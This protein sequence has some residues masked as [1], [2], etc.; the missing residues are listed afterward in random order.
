MKFIVKHLID[1]FKIMVAR[2]PVMITATDI[3][4]ILGILGMSLTLAHADPRT[5]Q[6]AINT[7]ATVN[8]VP[9]ADPWPQAEERW[10]DISGPET[11]AYKAFLDG[12]QKFSYANHYPVNPATGQPVHQTTV[13]LTYDKAPSVPYFVGHIEARGLKPN[14]AYQL[15]LAG[16]PVKGSRGWGSYGD[17]LTN[18]RIGAVGRWWCDSS[19]DLQTNFNDSHFQDF[20]H[21]APSNGNPVHDIYAYQ[22]CG[23]FITDAQGNASIDFTSQSSYHVTWAE[24]QRIDDA[25]AG[26]WTLQNHLVD[27]TNMLY[28]GYGASPTSGTYRLY[29]EY[30]GSGRP[31]NNVVLPPGTY[32]CRFLITEESFHSFEENG[33]YWKTVLASE[34]YTPAPGGGFQPDTDPVNDIVFK[35]AGP[36]T[37][38]PRVSITTP[39][40]GSV[41]NILTAIVGRA[42]DQSGTG[43]KAVDIALR[44]LSDNK[45]WMGK[46][47]GSR[48]LLSAT[49]DGPIWT[50][51]SLP[52]GT[53]LTDGSYIVGANVYDNAAKVSSVTSSFTLDRTNPATLTISNPGHNAT[54][55]TLETINGTATD[56]SGGTGIAR[57]DVVLK[58]N[59]DSQ[60]WTGS[61]WGS[62]TLLR[63]TLNQNN[64]TY[65]GILPG[66]TNL[67][68][69]AYIVAAYAYDRAGNAKAV[70]HTFAARANTLPPSVLISTP[71]N[72]TAVRSFD[73]II[74]RAYDRS[75]S[76]IGRVDLALKRLSDN[77]Y[78]TGTVWGS[79]TLLATTLNGATWTCTTSLPSGADLLDGSYIVGANAYDNFGKPRSVTGT[80]TLDRAIPAT[81]TIDSPV[82]N[83]QVTVLS[84]INGT[85][86]DNSGGTGIVRVDMV[87]K[88]NSDG[89]YW[90]GN[91]WT[92]RTLLA[93]TLSGV[94]WTYGRMPGGSNLLPG[95]YTVAAYAYDY[96]RNVRSA[97]HNFTVVPGTAVKTMSEVP[98]AVR[99]PYVL[100]MASAAIEPAAIRLTF[101]GP[102]NVSIT[103]YD[104]RYR[105]LV[106]G[107]SILLDRVELQGS[108]VVILHLRQRTLD[109]GD[110]VKVSYQLFDVQGRPLQGETSFVVK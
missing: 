88:R 92:I 86:T 61:T 32:N 31:R 65:S 34:D 3:A 79:R 33:G 35:I 64:W 47:W 41:I 73:T 90:S 16:K 1:V 18:E 23:D 7:P 6:A 42:Y 46:A 75:G 109:S 93:A 78:W 101:T 99:S 56:N 53:D 17:D 77:K 52:I 20:Y 40:N 59:S 74:G 98:V 58:R 105:V 24:W 11:H 70:T 72:G 110:E 107:E 96:A 25:P 13:Q 94:N 4:A 104:S 21:G 108:T 97:S 28:Y 91:V 45:Y 14:F 37:S 63:S 10:M 62:R 2:M 49:L 87:L 89:K 60:Y 55:A 106:N 39:R 22:M 26:T 30:E 9:Y 27:S 54:V 44:R 103:G 81:L 36:P 48:T 69:G 19:H 12:T 76:G 57:V 95:S 85:A 80:F 71:F 82:G 67:L 100:S 68:D 15:K 66:G 50:C 8:L 38:P 102:L 84:G 51:N 83:A 43:L 29:Y 5:V